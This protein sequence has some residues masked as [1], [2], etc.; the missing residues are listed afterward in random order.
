MR[1]MYP[2]N[3]S[4]PPL[5]EPVAKYRADRY[6]FRDLP[7]PFHELQSLKPYSKCHLDNAVLF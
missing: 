2:H 6:L 5:P 3:D 7:Y 4:R 1:D